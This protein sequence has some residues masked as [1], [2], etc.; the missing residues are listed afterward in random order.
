MQPQFII[1]PL[2]AEMFEAGVQLTHNVGTLRFRNNYNTHLFP[3]DAEYN[4]LPSLTIPDQSLTIREIMTRNSQGL[5]FRDPQVPLYDD[6]DD[7]NDYL[8][9]IQT[10]D[11]QERKEL[12]VKT[13]NYLR[14]FQERYVQQEAEKANKLKQRE[15]AI[16]EL[17]T[18]KQPL[19][20]PE[21]G[22]GGGY[23]IS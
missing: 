1:S 21:G 18:K 23:L 8:P 10:L 9:D 5:G 7:F 6:S 4:P 22:Q 20:P 12:M 17:L 3:D 14:A 13:T 15:E 16:E 2:E 11:L 19:T